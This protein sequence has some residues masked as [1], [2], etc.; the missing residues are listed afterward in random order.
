MTLVAQAIP[1]L[2]YKTN[3]CSPDFLD[4]CLSPV[5][6]IEA[7]GLAHARLAALRRKLKAGHCGADEG[8][9]G[10]PW[11]WWEIAARPVVSSGTTNK[12][13]G[14]LDLHS[15]ANRRIREAAKR[16]AARRRNPFRPRFFH[17]CR[18]F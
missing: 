4:V 11:A 16:R 9:V 8:R 3:S 10:G 2:R 18:L 17:N 14:N 13:S 15:A 5:D 6:L 7:V 12:P 1:R